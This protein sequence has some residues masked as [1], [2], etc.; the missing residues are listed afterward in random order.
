[1]SE[2][3]FLKLGGS[4]ITDKTRPYTLRVEKL[5]T[6][7]KEIHAVLGENPQ[8]RL[9]VGH[10]SGSFGHY[11]AQEHLPPSPLPDAEGRQAWAPYWRGFAEVWYRATQLNRHVVEAL[12]AEAVPVVAIQPSASIVSR[13]GVIENWNLS[14]LESALEAGIL[15]VIYGDMAFDSVRG[16]AVL[17]TETLMYYLAG[18]LRPGRI[19]LAGLIFPHATSGSAR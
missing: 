19:L 12:H 4:L 11:A 1:M 14:P 7:A 16:G 9:V 3:V 18:H 8:L 17:S 13:D 15:P 2:L 10:G 6:L 5:K